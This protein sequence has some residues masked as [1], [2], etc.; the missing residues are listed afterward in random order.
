MEQARERLLHAGLKT[1]EA[2]TDAAARSL[3][4]ELGAALKQV[5]RLDF[6]VKASGIDK[7]RCSIV[8]ALRERLILMRDR[9]EIPEDV[10]YSL[11]EELDRAALAAS[12]G[13]DLMLEEI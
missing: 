9:G 11:Q 3:R 4:S 5:G 7:L 1:L 13:D 12:P 2:M 6:S 8:D 10:F